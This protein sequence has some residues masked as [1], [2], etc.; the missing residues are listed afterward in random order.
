MKYPGLSPK[1]IRPGDK[2]LISGTAGDHG[3]AVMLA[4]G[5]MMQ[6]KIKSDCA[7]LNGLVRGD[8]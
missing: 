6:G 5:G 2:V 3:T 8:A 1:A 7:A 4:R